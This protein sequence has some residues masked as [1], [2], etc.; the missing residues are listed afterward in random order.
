M[1]SICIAAYNEVTEIKNNADMFRC[2]LIIIVCLLSQAAYA[3]TKVRYID[4]FYATDADNESYVAAL[5]QRV[6][7]ITED[8]YGPFELKA[9]HT[10]MLQG[11]Q[12][13]ALYSDEIDVMW[14]MTSQERENR[15]LPIRIP[16]A[17][18]LIGFRVFV[19][20]REQQDKFSQMHDEFEL[21]KLLAVQGHDW[22]DLK[23]L[24]ANGFQVQGVSWRDQMYT[25]LAGSN[26]DYFPR[27]ITEVGRELQRVN[28]DD[29]L[30]VERKW[31]LHY[32]AAT[33]FFVNRNNAQLAQ[34]LE[35][36]LNQL[37]VSGELK[38]MLLSH[39]I[40][41][42]ALQLMTLS[43]RT[44]VELHNPLLPEKT[45]LETSQYWLTYEELIQR[46]KSQDAK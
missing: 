27:G 12:F 9:E 43:G 25:L 41:Q 38:E 29:T 37:M 32:R 14:A 8:E 23:I 22:P 10:P 34:R 19:I 17:M 2:M 1:A 26:F 44:V 11:R 5:L 30:V 35:S 40:H 39:P 45:P 28:I 21:K 13:R 46:E 6:M 36:G 18:G 42:E 7:E 33:Y 3:M 15:A 4:P 16:I 20:R 24:K 31:L